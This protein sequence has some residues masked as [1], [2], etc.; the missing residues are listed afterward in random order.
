MLVATVAVV[1]VVV[2]SVVWTTG[3]V[4]AWLLDFCRSSCR[5]EDELNKRAKK[6]RIA[7]I[8][9]PLCFVEAGATCSA[10]IGSTPWALWRDVSVTYASWEIWAA[11]RGTSG[12][13]WEEVG[14]D[15]D[16]TCLLLSKRVLVFSIK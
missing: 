10:V 1:K 5:W 12:V 3:F 9:P 6:L 7:F 4:L 11:A 13:G 14:D 16:N 8:G 15:D 2:V